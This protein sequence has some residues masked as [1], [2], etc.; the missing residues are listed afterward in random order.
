VFNLQGEVLYTTK[1]FKD[2]KPTAN[3]QYDYT[4]H[5]IQIPVLF[6][7]NLP[8]PAVSPSAY[9][10]PAIAFTTKAEFE[11]QDGD[12]V[13]VKDDMESQVWS[14]ILGVDVT[15]MNKLIVDLRYDMDLDAL[16]KQALVDYDK[17]IKGRTITMMVGF[18]F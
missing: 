17:D 5:S 10:G 6:K 4:M 8:I 7:F 13:D 12:T 9:I 15:L 2:A 14:L 1:G 18:Q 11:D 3:T 16:N